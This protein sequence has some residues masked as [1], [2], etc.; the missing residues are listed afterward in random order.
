MALKAL[1]TVFGLEFVCLP[2]VLYDRS[3]AALLNDSL[4]YYTGKPQKFELLKHD[5]DN[6]GRLRLSTVFFDLGLSAD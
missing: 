3:C 6:T 2:V 1:I 5:E 4:R